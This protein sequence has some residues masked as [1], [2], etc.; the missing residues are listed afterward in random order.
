[1]LAPAGTPSEVIAILAHSLQA[2]LATVR[3]LMIERGMEN[4]GL[5][6]QQ[7]STYLEQESAMWRR[8]IAT[9][10]IELQN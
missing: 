3:E 2:C 4:F 7:F 5:E 9:G 10:K 8:T 6:R 1:V